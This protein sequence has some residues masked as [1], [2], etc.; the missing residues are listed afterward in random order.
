MILG[1]TGLVAVNAHPQHHAPNTFEL[2]KRGIDLEDYSMPSLSSYTK[3]SSASSKHD[4]AIV[5]DDYVAIAIALAKDVAHGAEFRVVGDHY[6]DANGVAHINLRQTVH[7]LDIDNA[8][9]NIN[10]CIPPLS[11]PPSQHK[12]ELINNKFNRSR[13]ERSSL[14]ETASIP[15]NCPRKALW[16]SG[17]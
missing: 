12:Q 14:M 5:S 2:A 10:V 11:A 17:L 6:V 15:A 16:R 3:T 13:M 7:G 8:D 1:L 9:F 4:F